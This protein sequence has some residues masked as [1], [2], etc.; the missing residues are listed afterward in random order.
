MRRP[1]DRGQGC[2]LGGSRHA[3]GWHHGHGADRD[4]EGKGAEIG[5]IDELGAAGHGREGKWV[6]EHR[7]HAGDGHMRGRHQILEC[8]L[9][10]GEQRCWGCG[11]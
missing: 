10:A 8:S 2:G 3:V 9:L 11:I 6:R 1:R 4:R 7:T 5:I